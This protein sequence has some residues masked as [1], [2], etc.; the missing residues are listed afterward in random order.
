MKN[1]PLKRFMFITGVLLFVGLLAAA[2]TPTV[3]TVEVGEVVKITPADYVDEFASSEHLLIDVRTPEEF[4][5]GYIDNAINIPLDTIEERLDE[6]PQDET[7]VLY[8]RSG[9]RSGQA[10]TILTEL[11]YP[12]IYDM[13]GII[14]WMDYGLPVVQ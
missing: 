12:V 5:D 3:P 10:A 13:G 9:N 7:V 8:C 11:G 14:D 1:Q 2:C 6:I 4:A